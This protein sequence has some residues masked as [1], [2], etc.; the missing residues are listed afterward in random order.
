MVLLGIV[1]SGRKDGSML[2]LGLAG[3]VLFEDLLYLIVVPGGEVLEVF[4]LAGCRL[5]GLKC[6][7]RRGTSPDDGGLDRGGRWCI[8]KKGV[9]KKRIVG[10]IQVDRMMVMGCEKSVDIIFDK[11]DT[12]GS[13][14][15]A[16]Q[17]VFGYTLRYNTVGSGWTNGGVVGLLVYL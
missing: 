11:I 2:E 8:H 5:S 7:R 12:R 14:E 1:D 10:W 9:F 16:I 15:D 6:S 17:K 3:D 4:Y 13:F